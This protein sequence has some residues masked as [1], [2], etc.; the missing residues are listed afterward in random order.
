VRTRE[1]EKLLRETERAK[2]RDSNDREIDL[3]RDALSEA[4]SRLGIPWPILSDREIEQ[5]EEEN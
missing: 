4:L 3:L 5:L 2:Y 1:F